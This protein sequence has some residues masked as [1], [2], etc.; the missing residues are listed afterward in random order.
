M[1]I[2]HLIFFNRFKKLTFIGFLILIQGFASGQEKTGLTDHSLVAEGFQKE[3]GVPLPTKAQIDDYYRIALQN[4]PRIKAAYA[5]WQASVENIA[6][7]KNLPDPR[8]SFGYF[9]ENVETK[10]GPQ[11]YRI[12]LTQMIPW[13]GKLRLQGDIQTL[14]A[15][16]EFQHLQS[17]INNLYFQVK[18]VV[19]KVYYLDQSVDIM[20]QN[21][22]LVQNWE[23]VVRN[24]YKTATVGHPD[25]IK[26]QI[27]RIKLQDDLQTLEDRYQ[28]LIEKMGALVNDSTV[29]FVHIPDSLVYIP[30]EITREELERIILE[31]N[32][33][34]LMLNFSQ[35][36]SELSI[37]RARLNYYPDLGIGIDYIGT[38]LT[39]QDPLIGMVSLSFPLWFKKQKAGVDAARYRQRQDDEQVLEMENQLR[40]NMENIWF[41]LIDARRKLSL[42]RNNLI[43]KSLE[44]LRASEK[45]YIA[46]KAD[47]INLIDAQRL[48]LKF[49]LEYERSLVLYTTAYAKLEN[50]AGREL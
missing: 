37:K 25:L 38:G 5:K 36:A 9:L 35:D 17:V 11:E 15:D 24:K 19:Y 18:D 12:G 41:E 2:K 27:E 13:F 45:A 46:D 20:K 28:P 43:P 8:L 34:L 7:V 42:Y 44:S 10:V 23:V 47:F 39:S 14:K 32:P 16:A 26:T 22:N 48:Y 3:N 1:I 31:S 40:V 6:V 29:N 50:I 4:N 49:L 33:D 21:I 30:F